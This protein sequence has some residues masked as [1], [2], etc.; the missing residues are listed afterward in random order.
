MATKTNSHKIFTLVGNLGHDP[1]EKTVPARQEISTV[2][3][4]LIDGPKEVVIDR[5]ELNFLTYSVAC[6]GKNGDPVRWI[7]CVDWEGEAFRARKG[8]RVKLTGYFENRTYTT[9]GGERK[10]VRQLV[11]VT[12]TIDKMKCRE[13]E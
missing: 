7:N 4:P 3:C 5:P 6:G 11:V 12:A 1:E 8:D 13:I 2:Y 9:K 10:T